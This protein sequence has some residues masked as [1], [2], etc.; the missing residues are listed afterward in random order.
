MTRDKLQEA[1]FDEEGCKAGLHH[2]ERYHKKWNARIG[3][4]SDEPEKLD[5]HSEAADALRQWAQGYDPDL[6]NAP[7]HVTRRRSGARI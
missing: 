6:L 7:T 5:G 3:A 1:W 4:F 2:V